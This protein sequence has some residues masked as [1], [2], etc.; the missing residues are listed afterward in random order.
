MNYDLDKIDE[1]DNSKLEKSIEK[2]T[3]KVKRQTYNSAKKA[4]E[5]LQAAEQKQKG[6][7]DEMRIQNEKLNK[8]QKEGIKTYKNVKK[9]ENQAI[10]LEEGASMFNP[11]SGVKSKMNKWGNKNTIEDEE[12]EKL[13]AKYNNKKDKD[14]KRCKSAGDASIKENLGGNGE[15]DDELQKIL[16]TTRNIANETKV[17]KKVGEK[18]EVKLNDLS[19]TIKYS[20]EKARKADKRLKKN[21]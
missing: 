4:R 14:V 13:D 5:R 15:L 3:K 6:T 17:Q 18:Q 11:V 21:L 20:D 19:K 10:E 12:I 2:E 1:K 8:A 7:T 16:L 9:A